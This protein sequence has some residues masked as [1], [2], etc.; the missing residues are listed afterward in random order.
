MESKAVTDVVIAGGVITAPV[1]MADATIWMQFL[2]AGIGL[3]LL[4]WRVWKAY[5]G[6]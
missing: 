5:K 2:G 6:K 4:L 3:G 1:W